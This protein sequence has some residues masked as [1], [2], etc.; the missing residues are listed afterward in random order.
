[1]LNQS[2]QEQSLIANKS[3]L[4]TENSYQG[5][6]SL[7]PSLHSATASVCIKLVNNNSLCHYSTD[8]N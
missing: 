6:P 2:S 7:L 8:V 4:P 5:A 3:R 1:M